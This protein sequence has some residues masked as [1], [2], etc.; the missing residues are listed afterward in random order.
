[1]ERIVAENIP[2]ALI[3]EDDVILDES[4]FTFLVTLDTTNHG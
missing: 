4:F 1:M 3:L 2:L